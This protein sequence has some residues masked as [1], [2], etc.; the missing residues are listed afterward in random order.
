MFNHQDTLKELNKNAPLGEKLGSIHKVIK[1]QCAFIGRIAVA[2]Y[3]PKTD[4]LKTYVSSTDGSSPL[5]HYQAPLSSAPSLQEIIK[6]KTPRV[7]NDLAIF[8]QDTPPEKIKEHTQ[9]L[10]GKGY[11]SSYTMPMYLND[12]FFGFVFFNSSDRDPF[13][14]DTLHYLDLI[15]H[16]VSLLIINEQTSIR[17]LLATVKTAHNITHHRDSETGAHLDRMSRYSHLIAMHIADKYALDDEYIEN[18]FLYSPLHDIGKIAIADN[19]L[20]KPG[21]LDANE[22][23]IMQTH[24]SKGREIIDSMLQDH[25][26]D[27]FESINILRNIAE[28]HHEAINGSGYPKGLQ[29]EEIPLEARIVSVA[30]VFDALT[31]RRTYKEAW[32]NEDAYAMLQRL[33]GEK[34]DKD[35]VEALLINR[36]QVEEIQRIFVEDELG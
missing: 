7:V 11:A 35:C 16:L 21:K 12:I 29:G 8:S 27:G 18:V 25:G 17:T 22:F 36:L 23:E 31:S 9:K 24:A 15:G 1:S 5:E 2:I 13:S 10:K 28:Y 14:D 26:L 30:D 34:L 19:I 33:A 4:I 3:D 20:K 32:S 6:L